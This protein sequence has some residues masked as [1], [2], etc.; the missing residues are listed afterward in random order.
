M[1]TSLCEAAF[2]EDATNIISLEYQNT[3][4]LIYQVTPQLL[5]TDQTKSKSR[6]WSP[7]VCSGQ[8]LTQDS[9]DVALLL[10][11]RPERWP[12]LSDPAGWRQSVCVCVSHTAGTTTAVAVGYSQWTCA[13]ALEWRLASLMQK[14]SCSSLISFSLFSS[15]NKTKEFLMSTTSI[16]FWRMRSSSSRCSG[17]FSARQ[18][19]SCTG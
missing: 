1:W 8:A 2:I 18:T 7:A 4:C 3:M 15:R 9:A 11:D 10:E 5:S 13:P 19:Q 16:S 12:Q 14:A 17:V 6:S